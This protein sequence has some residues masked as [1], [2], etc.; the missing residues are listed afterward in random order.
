MTLVGPT[1][2]ALN[3]YFCNVFTDGDRNTRDFVRRVGDDIAMKNVTFSSSVR[4]NMIR[5]IYGLSR[6]GQPNLA[7]GTEP[8]K[9]N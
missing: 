4:Y 9:D 7:P 1:V 3:E 6:D 2:F 5:Y 8:A